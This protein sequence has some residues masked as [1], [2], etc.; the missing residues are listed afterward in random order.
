ML[1]DQISG[2]GRLR[3]EEKV[4][5]FEMLQRVRERFKEFLRMLKRNSAIPPMSCFTLHMITVEEQRDSGPNIHMLTR[6]L[7]IPGKGYRIQMKLTGRELQV[8]KDRNLKFLERY[9]KPHFSEDDF[10]HRY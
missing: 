10:V 4:E 8:V 2:C 6:Q 3:L 1:E 9:P 5:G 7:K